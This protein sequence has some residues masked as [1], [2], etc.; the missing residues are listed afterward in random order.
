M[1]WRLVRR[2]LKL[3]LLVVLAVVVYLG[4]TAAQVWLTSR[5]DDPHRAQAIVVMGA[6]Q[7]DGVPSPDLQ[8]RLS[9]ALQAWEQGLAPEIVTT[10]YKEP[11]DAYTES[12]TGKIWLSA[13]G[14]PASDIVEVGGRTSY[15]NLS[16]AAAVL[17]P[18][19]HTDVLVVT[20]GFH[21]D[22]SMAIASDVGLTPAP[23][24]AVD[25][26]IRGWSVVPYFARETVGVAVGRIV[27]YQHLE[28]LDH[29]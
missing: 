9:T 12:E 26:P 5:H 3:L 19:G 8:A 10:G 18:Q 7:Y 1:A 24:P 13:H 27:G 17:V 4:V 20:D 16:Q 28:A 23:V 6:A 15:A 21:E 29:L 22:L 2:L 14:V 25:S 11:G